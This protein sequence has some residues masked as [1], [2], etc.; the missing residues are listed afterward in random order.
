MS[1]HTCKPDH[2]GIL[3]DGCERCDEHAAEPMLL[4]LDQQ[5]MEALWDKMIS[6]E[7]SSGHYATGNEAKA[8]RQLYNLAI[9]LERYVGV[10]PWRSLDALRLWEQHLR[11]I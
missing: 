7:R 3:A 2:A 5:K 1:T 11:I 6:V 9:W 10:D 4:W 8:A